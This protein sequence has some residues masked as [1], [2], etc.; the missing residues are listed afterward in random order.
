M[1]E[2]AQK[3]RTNSIFKLCRLPFTS[4]ETPYF[5]FQSYHGQEFLHSEL[6]LSV[7]APLI[8]L[9]ICREVYNTFQSQEILKPR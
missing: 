4:V 7:L 5:V 1:M 8:L 9:Q 2:A 6:L 3:S